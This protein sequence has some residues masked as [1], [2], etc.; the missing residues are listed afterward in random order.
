MANPDDPG[1]LAT[2]FSRAHYHVPALG[3]AGALRVG[4]MATALE[5]ACPARNFAFITAW[6]SN[7]GRASWT[8]NQRADGAL[9]AEL[10]HLQAAH[11]RAV[12]E[13][14]QG[15]HREEGWLVRD[16][17]LDTLDCLARRFGQDGVLA[18]DSGSPVRLRLYHAAPDAA[19]ARMPF[20]DWVGRA[21][22]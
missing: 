17:T 9:L 1:R 10:E 20:V 11:V 2:A 19:A 15:G 6:A 8:E 18:W 16:L 22:W 4:T 3:D 13:D 7:S 12:A 5:Q 21:R 14:A